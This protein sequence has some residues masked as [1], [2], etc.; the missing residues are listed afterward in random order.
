MAKLALAQ[1][2]QQKLRDAD[3]AGGKKKVL[4]TFFTLFVQVL[5]SFFAKRWRVRR[6]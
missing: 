4:N 2:S 5:P 3:P 6:S 1:I